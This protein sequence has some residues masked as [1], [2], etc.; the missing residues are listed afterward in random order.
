MMDLLPTF[1]RLAGAEAPK[2]RVIDG[3]DIWPLM[4]GDINANSP[5]EAFYYYY[6]GQ[7]QAVR[8]GRW[9]L[10]LPL[11]AKCRNFRG[12]TVASEA[13]LYD[14]KTDV[15]ETKNLIWEHPDILRR[16]LTLAEKAR[17]DLGDVNRPGTHQRPA[18]TVVNPSARVLRK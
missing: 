15:G 10:H 5:Y 12:D 2:D 18:G 13:E 7:I 8:S 16:L 6:A 1:A 11:A 4:A 3:Y 9:K 17:V 14:L